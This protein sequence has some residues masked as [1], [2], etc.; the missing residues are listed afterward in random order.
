MR[1][2]KLARYSRF[3]PE[4]LEQGIECQPLTWSCYGREYPATSAALTLLARRA[5]RR[6]GDRPWRHRLRLLRA[7]VG[8]A[9]ARR[10]AAMVAA[11]FG[12]PAG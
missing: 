7:G 10:A 1:L 2:R 11:C 6:Q 3:V 5:A 12:A 8:A 9:L 4:L